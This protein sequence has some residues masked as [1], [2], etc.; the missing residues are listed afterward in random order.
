MNKSYSKIRHIQESN[1]KLEKK[2]LIEQDDSESNK[3]F[4]KNKS[5]DEVREALMNISNSVILISIIGCEYADFDGVDICDEPNELNYVFI[6]DTDNNFEEQRYMCINEI[7]S[8]DVNTKMYYLDNRDS[9]KYMNRH[10]LRQ[11]GLI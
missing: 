3:L 1:L 4:L 5:A 2:I 8:E 10:M 7:D 6:K 11:L 9:Y